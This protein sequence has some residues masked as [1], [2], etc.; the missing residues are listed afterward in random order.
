MATYSY[1]G[2]AGP[3][4]QF[5]CYQGYESATAWGNGTWVV[6]KRCIEV[7][8]P[9]GGSG[10]RGTNVTT[11]YAGTVTL[12]NSTTGVNTADRL[13]TYGSTISDGYI[14][15]QYTGG[16]GTT[17]KSQTD[18][19]S[20]S[21]SNPTYTVTY[22]AN[23]GSVSPAS[24][25]FT[26]GNAISLPTP[27]RTGYT[28]TRWH[29]NGSNSINLAR[30]YMYTNKFSVHF[31][32][33]HSNWSQVAN[34][35]LISC[36]ESGG[37]NVENG[38][39]APRFIAY[40]GGYKYAHGSLTWANMA[41]GWHTFDLIFTGSAI[42]IYIDGTQRGT[43]SCGTISYHNWNSIWFGAEASAKGSTTD[44]LTFTG[45]LANLR[46]A[47]NS[48]R[49]SSNNTFQ[50]PAQNLT[51]YA[52]WTA[53]TYTVSYNANGGT[54]APSAQSYTYASS[55]TITLS[56]TKPTRSGY[57][58]MGWGTSAT[59]TSAD[60][61]AGGTYN[62]NYAGNRTLYAI[63]R[64]TIKI[65]YNANGGGTAPSADSANIY[66]ATT[67][68]S[69]TMP[70]MTRT[71][72]TLLGWSTSSS[73]TS[74]SYNV[75]TAYSFSNSATLYAV[76][77]VN[78]FT[79]TYNANGG[80]GAPSNQTKTYGVDLTLSSTKP[81]REGYKFVNWNTKPD[82]SGTSYSSGGSYTSN[83]AVTLYAQWQ[84]INNVTL[85]FNSPSYTITN[86]LNGKAVLSNLNFT[87]SLSGAD[88]GNTGESFWFTPYYT[89]MGQK[90][91]LSQIG[92]TSI[93]ANA[94]GT[95]S[96]TASTI[97]SYLQNTNN[98]S[99]IELNV[100]VFTA[101][102]NNNSYKTTSSLSPTINNYT[103]PYCEVLTAHRL[104]NNNIYVKARIV[105][106]ASYSN[107]G[108][109]TPILKWGTT[110]LGTVATVKQIS[111]NVYE[112]TYEISASSASGAST[113]SIYYTDDIFDSTGEKRV[114]ASA[115]DQIF[116]II[117]SSG[118]CCAFEFIET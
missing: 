11:N 89:A 56:S 28:F 29:T 112:Y 72:Y 110:T 94:T 8:V 86:D 66:N 95:Y 31:E 70:S 67:S 43:T 33:Y 42:T 78:T 76:W 92:P 79:V 5:R 83:S 27:T 100:D 106:P 65:T 39:N 7:S 41:A 109:V 77:K 46:I 103:K 53:N 12:Y 6:R 62:R 99:K 18:N 19:I 82:G 59:D 113:V 1:G 35:R 93:A 47:N 108:N 84:K 115:A 88:T 25:T 101:V 61:S 68:R 107:L 26:Y 116:K 50:S 52:E 74:A 80:S 64:K 36:T 60:W 37:W 34:E 69:V 4:S 17:Y 10:F 105:Y 97:K 85:S 14:Y 81:T 16:S 15:A 118:I 54:G 51:L 24:A 9:S 20:Y 49:V 104:S 98:I 3:G 2:W 13:C 90:I 21:V 102:N 71:G 111:T 45:S 30:K 114:A 75:G 63:W 22:N 38:N 58:F 87:W 96:L 91:S 32:A 57:T 73:A 55:G 40:S 48:T 44:G 117:K 23:G